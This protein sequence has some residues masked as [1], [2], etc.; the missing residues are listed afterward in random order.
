[1]KLI[2]DENIVL[3]KEAFESFGQVVFQNGRAITNH[4][5][6]NADVLIV[7]SITDVNEKLLKETNVKFVGTATIGTDHIDL[8][9]QKKN[10]IQFSSA[11]GC[12]SFSVAEYV[13][14]AISHLV[15]K[16]NLN[17]S[18]MSIGVVGYGNIGTKVV[19]IAKALG[20]KV[21]INDPPL[22]RISNQNIFSPLEDVLKCDIITFHV[23]LNLDGIDKTVHLL[24]EQN[25][26]NLKE[27]TI[28][29]NSSRGPV[30][31]NN[32]LKM[33]LK[34]KNNIHTV[35][36]VWETEPNFD[37]DLFKLVEIG[38]PHIAGYS[39][40]GKINGT[41]IIYDALSNYLKTPATWKPNFDKVVDNKIEISDNENFVQ[42]IQKLFNKSYKIIDDDSLMRKV[43]DFAE[44]ERGK[45][46]D[47]LRKT[48]RKR[49]E[50]NNY[51]A[52]IKTENSELLNLLKVLRINVL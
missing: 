21:I 34:L 13:F 23:P 1:M 9:Y 3:G 44:D 50:L 25:L 42:I 20:M 8:D 45:H 14:S 31:D 10:S 37:I 22:E 7:R 18:N 19:K 24:N 29:I 17:L 51:E 12:N 38:T 52:I 48:Y 46:F 27:N 47:M 43:F 16:H 4:C 26:S 41:K 39:Y 32:A 30:V 5:L 11:A 36:D 6:K 33:R 40:E 35:L 15:I 49:R 2:V 28:L